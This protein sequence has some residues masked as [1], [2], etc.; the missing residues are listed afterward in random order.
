MR[1]IQGISAFG[2]KDCVA[3]SD[4][5]CTVTDFYLADAVL[6]QSALGYIR[7][8]YDAK[9][10]RIHS[11]LLWPPEA[12]VA[13]ETPLRRVPIPVAWSLLVDAGD[14]PVRWNV[15]KGISIP[16]ANILAAHIKGLT[17][18]GTS[19]EMQGD[20]VVAIPDHLD[21]FGQEALLQALGGKRNGVKLIWRPVAA[22]MAWLDQA[23][24][25]DLATED[26]MLV[27][28]MGPDAMEFSTFG[29]REEMAHGKR[30]VLPV[31]NRPS[32]APLPAGWEWACALSA[33]VDPICQTD[34]GAFWQ[35]FTN[36]PEIWSAITGSDWDAR[37][38]P[39]PWSTQDKGWQLWNPDPALRTKAYGCRLDQSR[40]LRELIGKS[41]TLSLASRQGS[42]STWDE[43]FSRELQA[44]LQH[45]E[46]RLRGAVLCGPLAPPQVP[47]WLDQ[48]LAGFPQRQNPHQDTI[49]LPPACDDPVAM[50][51]R[52]FG[53][54]TAAQPQL[55]TYL[56]TLPGLALLTERQGELDWVDI[57]KSSEC[58]GGQPYTQSIENKFFLSHN[59]SSMI[60]Y[61][62]KE[63]RDNDGKGSK[64]PETKFPRTVIDPVKEK[65]KSLGSLEAVF[66]SHEWDWRPESKDYA[67]S[68]ARWYYW[69]PDPAKSPFRHGSVEFPSAPIRDVQL[70]VNVE[71]R[72]ASGLARVEF[73][74]QK[75][76]ALK[77]RPVTFDYSRM[78]PV[79]EMELPEPKLRWPETL[80]FETTSDPNAF[81]DNR[82]LNFLHLSSTAN[83]N[84]FISL[85]NS[86]KDAI[87]SGFFD[88][89]NNLF[90][91]RIDENGKSGSHDGDLCIS[92]IA[93]CIE[94][95]SA[96]FLESTR[97]GVNANTR[98]FILRS[99]WL[100]A[101]TPK[102]V[103]DY[104]ERY[105]ETHQK[106]TYDSVW[107]HFVESA[108]RC[109]TKKKQFRILFEHIYRR[110][111]KDQKKSLPIQAMRSLIHVLVRREWGWLV[112]EEKMA[113]HFAQRATEILRD[114]VKSNNVKQKFFQ[115]AFLILA[116]LNFRRVDPLFLDPD[117][118]SDLFKEIENCLING[119][120]IAYNQNN[121]TQL[122]TLI[123]QIINFMYSKG[124]K[125]II[126][127]VAEQAGG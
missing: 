47:G 91:K 50:G 38:L 100:W 78:A 23:S 56:D 116:L 8:G 49:W 43:L 125:G 77:G 26:Y 99:S 87:S 5:G 13:P 12:R 22:A 24:P 109:F 96:L 60:V 61:L 20:T 44:V 59:S 16:L 67:L 58:P 102:S 40:M 74:P 55:P 121:T 93:G 103:I 57:V 114:E 117:N 83:S 79:V 7:T 62:R 101:A 30:F 27:I 84:T 76:D 63:T 9:E 11:G 126:A 88:Q 97:N 65:V 120:K 3:A 34:H 29:L 4:Q 98:I 64:E 124:C 105:F 94:Q 46:G 82:I 53:E 17:G 86:M 36:F 39:R 51:A 69:K 104:L 35:T 68:F 92:R 37:Q 127:Q 122:D 72:P 85:L 6:P 41:C 115:G 28:Y 32:R 110:S 2:L 14:R 42:G 90:L 52:L 81:L 31:R 33:E 75:E 123:Q 71:M 1:R 106:T 108:G 118:K 45:R 73:V 107:N 10:E 25:T 89:N 111:I 54:R 18:N 19:S 80:H 66:E 15:G 112:L 113:I 48:T 119:A 70:T 95:R 21:E